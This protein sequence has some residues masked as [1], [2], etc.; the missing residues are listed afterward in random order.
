MVVWCTLA[1]VQ[2]ASI[3]LRIWASSSSATVPVKTRD[4]HKYTLIQQMV[5]HTFLDTIIK[6]KYTLI[7]IIAQPALQCTLKFWLGKAGMAIF[8]GVPW[9]LTSRY[10]TENRFYGY[11]RVS[12]LQ[13]CPLYDNHMQF[14][15]SHSQVST[16]THWQLLLPVGLQF[17][18]LWFEYIFYAKCSTCEGFFTI[19]VIVL[20]W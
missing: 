9:P 11:P 19:F 1:P 3:T 2:Y 7:K 10:V 16:L 17:A 15:A 18:M 8:T 4:D 13:T 5:S 12:P 14:G 20:C 6:N